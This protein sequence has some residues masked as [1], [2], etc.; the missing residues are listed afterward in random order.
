MTSPYFLGIPTIMVT[1]T[2]LL[3]PQCL[4]LP[5]DLSSNLFKGS[6]QY[7]ISGQIIFSFKLNVNFS[8]DI[9]LDLLKFIL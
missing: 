3:P 4:P 6:A 1:T 9:D 2:K 5:P 8:L 7:P